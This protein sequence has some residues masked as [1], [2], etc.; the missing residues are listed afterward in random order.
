M[1]VIGHGID[2]V[3][4]ARVRE[5]LERHGD[6]FLDRCFTPAEVD[7]AAAHP[8]R[9]DEHLA[10]RFAAKEAVL[11]A[12]G[13]GRRGGIA[14]TDV[15]VGRDPLGKPYATLAGEAAAVADRL[16]V[17]DWQL[18]LTHTDRQA[19][20]SALALGLPAVGP[21][22]AADRF[23]T[24]GY[25]AM[26]RGETYRIGDGYMGA[27]IAHSRVWCARYNALPA[28]SPQAEPML[29]EHLGS[30]G[31]VPEVLAPFHCDYGRHL[32]VG[33]RFFAN[34]GCVILDCADVTF[35]HRCFLGPGVHVYTPHHP[36]DPATRGEGYETSL[37]V[38]V[39]DDVWIGGHATILPGITIG[40]GTTVGAGSVVTKDVP[41]NVVAAGN[42]CRVLR[43]IDG[44]DRRTR[45]RD[46]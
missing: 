2:L 36:L 42:P 45:G 18:S 43:P 39:G 32:H 30:V 24:R 23:D 25:D 12:L 3:D 11:K 33:D 38:T 13:T 10:A 40:S 44:R 41:A 15:Q 7:Y 34:F 26:R 46:R 6:R 8:K 5:L 22:P 21:P 20:A 4:V 28:N 31:D 29:R 27:L 35:G 1:Q 14:W 37:P 16:G 17:L 9:R 19:S